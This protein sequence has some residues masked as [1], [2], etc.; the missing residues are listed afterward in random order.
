[1]KWLGFCND[2][3]WFKIK[4]LKKRTQTDVAI[5]LHRLNADNYEQIYLTMDSLYRDAG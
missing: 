3:H 2:Y 1:M 4:Q 5:A